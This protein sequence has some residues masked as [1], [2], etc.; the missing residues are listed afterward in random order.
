MNKKT[1]LFFNKPHHGL[2]TVSEELMSYDTLIWPQDMHHLFIKNNVIVP[3]VLNF[4]GLLDL[5]SVN[6]AEADVSQLRVIKGESA[7]NCLS[8]VGRKLPKYLDLSETQ[9]TS[10]N[11]QGADLSQTKQ[12]I[13]PK[14]LRDMNLINARV[15]HPINL[16]QCTH[17]CMISV[18]PEKV[19]ELSALC[20]TQAERRLTWLG[21]SFP[22]SMRRWIMQDKTIERSYE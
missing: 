1:E 9:V 6:L 2:L 8:F 19:K 10:I 12:L 11:F 14:T 17:L 18:L 4:H 21:I 22:V 16:S 15:I 5:E 3:P 13:L 7:L 20:Q